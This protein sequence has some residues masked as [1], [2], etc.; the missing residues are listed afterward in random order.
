MHY[1]EIASELY[2]ITKSFEG[3]MDPRSLALRM[4][5]CRRFCPIGRTGLW[6]LREWKHIETGTVADVAAELLSNSKTP[7]SE[8]VLFEMILPRRPVRLTS[9]RT[10]LRYDPR[11]VRVAP[12]LWALRP[13]QVQRSRRANYMRMK[14]RQ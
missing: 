6:A 8:S 2:R 4:S 7:L 3:R 1:R 10:L 9:V 13:L 12:A 14:D 5:Q 11:F